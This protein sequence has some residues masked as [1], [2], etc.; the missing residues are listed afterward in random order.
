MQPYAT[1]NFFKFSLNGLPQPQQQPQQQLYQQAQ[2]IV[3]VP[4]VQQGLQVALDEERLKRAQAEEKAR[5]LEAQHEASRVQIEAAARD[6]REERA[7]SARANERV[8]DL[9]R[10]LQQCRAEVEQLQRNVDALKKKVQSKKQMRKGKYKKMGSRKAYSELTDSGKKKRKATYKRRLHG[11]FNDFHQEVKKAKVELVIDGM[12]K[13]QFVVWP[14]GE[15]FQESR[16][17]DQQCPP[18]LSKKDLTPDDK[19]W[20]QKWLRVKDKFQISDSAIHEIRMLA[21]ERV[22]PLYI[23]QEER[24]EQNRMIPIV[25]EDTNNVARRPLRELLAHLLIHKRQYIDNNEVSV[26]FSGDGR[27]VTRNQRIGAVMGT[28][29]I[30]PKRETINGDT[31]TAQLHHTIDEEASVYIYEG[32]E[33]YETQKVAAASVYREMEDIKENGLDFEGRNIRVQ[34]Y[35]TADWKFAA[36]LLGLNQASSKSFCLWC[37]C[38]KEEICDFNIECWDVERKKGDCDKY[39][40]KRVHKGHI[41]PPLLDIDPE[42][43]VPDPLHMEMRV[44]GKLFNQAVVWNINQKREAE[45]LAAMKEIGVPFR[46]ME[47][48]GD[49]NKGS[50]KTW[51]Q[52]NAK[53]L[54]KVFAKLDLKAVLKDRWNSRGLSVHSLSVAQLRVE[55][56]KRGVDDKGRKAVLAN[57]LIDELGSDELPL[58][59]DNESS[60]GDRHPILLVDNIVKLWK[61]FEVLATALKAKPGAP[62]HLDPATFL[63]EGRKW[64]TFYRRATFDESVTPYIHTLIYHVPH[65]LSKYKYINDMSCESVEQ[66]N[67]MQNKRFHQGSQKSGRG[68]MWTKQVMEY[69]NRDLFGILNHLDR[70]KACLGPNAAARKAARLQEEIL[71]QEGGE[72]VQED[73]GQEQEDEREEQEDEEQDEEHFE[74]EDEDDS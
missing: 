44:R 15:V 49:D 70:Q 46:I 5:T 28:V 20:I 27:Q 19:R 22:P 54:E 73:E 61:D 66:K 41:L 24:K 42:E 31:D 17:D 12:D 3:Y 45:L 63:S 52:L 43:V 21:Q 38:T 13:P 65:F 25:T 30:I 72:E 68:S 37:H 23:I 35:L 32:G 10:V 56:R 53:Q 1:S 51:T 18:R 26:R 48:T 11:T 33:D 9:E 4:V 60:N 14:Q 74:D 57:R 71:A 69:E 67:H 2:Q 47:G 6:L 16:P 64:G 8:G 58:P 40:N 29:R 36:M 34:W 7:I 59:P 55:L 39:L 50:V 62:G